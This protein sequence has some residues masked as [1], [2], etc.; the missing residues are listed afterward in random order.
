M[1]LSVFPIR[2]TKVV[3][4]MKAYLVKKKHAEVIKYKTNCYQIEIYM[5]TRRRESRI[6]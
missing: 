5:D 6:S 3:A 2:R 1:T 4:Y